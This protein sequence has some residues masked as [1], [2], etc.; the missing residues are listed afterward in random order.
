MKKHTRSLS[1]LLAL[2]M[3]LNMA[4]GGRALEPEGAEEP[5]PV[6]EEAL[7]TAVP[8]EAP[9]PV[10]IPESEETPAPVE[11]PEP[12]EDLSAY[13]DIQN[14]VLKRYTG[15]GGHVVIPDEVTE[16]RERVFRDRADLTG[17][18]LP[19][20]LRRVGQSAFEGCTGLTGMYFPKQVEKIDIHAFQDC[21]GLRQITVENGDIVIANNAFDGCTGLTQV[22]LPRVLAHDPSAFYRMSVSI[23]EYFVVEN[24]LL[25]GYYGPGGDLMI[26]DEVTAIEG[27]YGGD[28]GMFSP[29]QNNTRL[30]SVTIPAG[31]TA[32]PM[33]LFSGCT[34]L[35]RVTMLGQVKSLGDC[36]FA[37]CGNLTD[38]SLPDSVTNIGSHCFDNCKSLTGMALPGGLTYL[39]SYCFSG[40]ER[41]TSLHIPAGVDGHLTGVF[42]GCTALT[43]LTID[44]PDAK[45]TRNDF[46]NC[47]NL[48]SYT[49]AGKEVKVE[50]TEPSKGGSSGSGNSLTKA[51]QAEK[52]RQEAI[53]RSQGSKAYEERLAANKEFLETHI[54]ER[55]Y[56]YTIVTQDVQDLSDELCEGLTTDRE[57]VYA[58]HEWVTENIYYDYPSLAG[59]HPAVPAQYVLD[60]K[61]YVCSGYTVLMQALCWAQKIPCVY[62]VGPTTNGYHAWNAVEIDGEWFWLDATWDTF[63][64][65]YG[66]DRWVKGDTRLDYFLCSTEFISTDHKAS[67]SGFSSSSRWVNDVLVSKEVTYRWCYTTNGINANLPDQSAEEAKEIIKQNNEKMKE[68]KPLEEQ[69]PAEEQ[70][71]ITEQKP[72]EEQNT[73]D[74]QQA[75]SEE[76][77]QL[78][79]TDPNLSDWA[80]DG[81]GEAFSKGLVPTLFI[82][83]YNRRI[84]REE[85]CELMVKLVEQVSTYSIDSY[86]KLRGL[87]YQM[88]FVDTQ[89][90]MVGYAATLGIVGGRGAGIFAPEDDISRQEAAVMLMR[91]AQVLGLTP[92]EKLD[93][94]DTQN[95]ESWAKEGVDFVS[96][97]VVPSTGSRVMNGT[98]NGTFSPFETYT[99]EQAILT[100]LALFKCAK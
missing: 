16:I 26:P 38:I 36:A 75:V 17:I 59:S 53:Q 68:E 60:R 10:E 35:T 47:P 85:F 94:R 100:A 61:T 45:V 74:W 20:G 30:T 4:P 87:T 83:G 86:T 92:G 98:G 33:S 46:Y 70:K 37:G 32:I 41:L 5:V 28:S 1:L 91:T 96:G 90:S 78:I 51:E 58:L 63:N 9:E 50:K 84:T 66:G 42:S 55:D 27:T 19:E 34:S 95:L 72:M 89:N 21:A 18:T 76:L 88:P 6:L 49:Q 69:K 29:F 77:R 64:K 15:P 8:E 97:L 43:D 57:K 13:F 22:A 93:F 82:G 14:G 56:I 25:T 65:Y 62:I 73:A 23:N 80:R 99:R 54:T 7:Q 39:G 31:V 2:V 67:N 48:K 52:S 3:C 71:P 81:V 79:A 12:A 24:G 44:N 40:C 11:T